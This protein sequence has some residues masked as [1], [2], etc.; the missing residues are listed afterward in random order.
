MNT[1]EQ[2]KKVKAELQKLRKEY[3]E[4]M[5]DNAEILRIGLMIKARKE[6]LS[7]LGASE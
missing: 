3:I 6:L 4:S 2:I 5:H 1:A 7:Q